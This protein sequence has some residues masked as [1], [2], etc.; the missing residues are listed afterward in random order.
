M[1]FLIVAIFAYRKLQLFRDFE[2]H[3]TITQAVTHRPIG[4]QYVHIA[5]TATLHNSSKVRVEIADDFLSVAP[6]TQPLS[7][8]E[9]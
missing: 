1:A 7:D 9:Y 3:L 6:N 5:V 2:P 4:T 8:D